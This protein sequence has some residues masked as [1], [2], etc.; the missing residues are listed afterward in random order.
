M[1]TMYEYNMISSCPVASTSLR[2]QSS[3]PLPTSTSSSSNLETTANPFKEGEADGYD[4]EPEYYWCDTSDNDSDDYSLSSDEYIDGEKFEGYW[5]PRLRRQ[6]RTIR[7]TL[8]ARARDYRSR[9]PPQDRVLPSHRLSS[10]RSNSTISWS[11]SPPLEGLKSIGRI[12]SPRS[13]SPNGIFYKGIAGDREKYRR[14]REGGEPERRRRPQHI[15][16]TYAGIPGSAITYLELDTTS[17]CPNITAGDLSHQRTPRPTTPKSM[18]TQN[19][20]VQKPPKHPKKAIRLLQTTV[21]LAVNWPA[22]ENWYRT[23]AARYGTP[24]DFRLASH[25]PSAAFVTFKSHREA[26]ECVRTCPVAEWSNKVIIEGQRVD[27]GEWRLVG[28]DAGRLAWGSGYN[29]GRA[30]Q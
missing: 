14:R 18:F 9:S 21:K 8:P 13:Q 10:A 5:E 3:S 17:S 15:L 25:L 19:G 20:S 7:R 2:E 22:S 27:E 30:S 26:A 23:V 28:V 11:G 24:I 6:G 12:R 4:S 29:S 1:N 16:D